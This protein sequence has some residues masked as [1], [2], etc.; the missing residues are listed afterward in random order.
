MKKTI[1]IALVLGLFAFTNAQNQSQDEEL[2]NLKKQITNLKG[3]NI[4]LEKNALELKNSLNALSVK[5]DELNSKL[6]VLSDSV[7]SKTKIIHRLKGDTHLIF[8]SLKHR[9]NLSIIAFII[10]IVLVLG[11]LLFV[12][13]KY[14][15]DIKKH[16]DEITEIKKGIAEDINKARSDFQS[17]INSAREGLEQKIKDQDKRISE[18][19]K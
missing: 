15:K 2:T 7:H 12:I 5:V 14:R 18:L 8:I 9:K 11:G 16:E 4:R 1:T 10:G 19:K 6:T 13:M 17:Q 3:K